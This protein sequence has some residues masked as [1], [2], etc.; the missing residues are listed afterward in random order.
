MG[1]A[2]NVFLD[3]VEGAGGMLAN[4]VVTNVARSKNS[5]LTEGPGN[6]APAQFFIA[7]FLVARGK[8]RSLRI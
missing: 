2:Y 6:Q 3:G 1:I 7:R 8:M 5:L 4:T